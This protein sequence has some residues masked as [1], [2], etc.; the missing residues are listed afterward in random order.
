[1][2]KLARSSSEPIG[3]DA[4]LPCRHAGV[5]PKEVIE[6]VSLLI[7]SLA[8]ETALLN[9][10]GL[11]PAEYKSALPL[12]IEAKRGSRSATNKRRRNF[13]LALLAEMKNRGLI[14]DLTRPHYGAD[15]VYR[16]NLHS[17]M[18]VAIIQKGCP[19][20][21]HSSLNWKRPEWADEAYLWWLCPSLA[22][23]PGEHVMKGI[24]RLRKKFLAAESR[25]LD[26]VIF[27]NEL[28]GTSKRPCPKMQRAVSI[29]SHAIPPPC[30]YI[31]PDRQS[32]ADEWNW[33]GNQERVFPT[34]LLSLFGI[35]EIHP[36]VGYV[37]FQNRGGVIRTTV[38]SRYGIGKST[39]FR[40]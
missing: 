28:C 4:A 32:N 2:T 20:G 8:E 25:F 21:A 30:I 7:D 13:L 31:L 38:A 39:T 35:D 34:V 9:A 18:Q 5:S 26:G 10:H 11:S 3:P 17:G 33:S 27:H 36:Y 14:D 37:G 15:T 16:L 1:M 22:S 40:S 12:V 6:R 29:Q 24:N 19:D 23:E